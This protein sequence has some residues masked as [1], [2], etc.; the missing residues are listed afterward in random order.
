MHFIKK[1]EEKRNQMLTCAAMEPC[2]GSTVV[3]FSFIVLLVNMLWLI[4]CTVRGQSVNVG[5]FKN[6]Y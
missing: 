5:F 6:S 2:K 3:C 1:K 4:S